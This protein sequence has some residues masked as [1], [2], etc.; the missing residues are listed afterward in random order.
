[1]IKTVRD[2]RWN[3]VGLKALIRENDISCSVDPRQCRCLLHVAC[4]TANIDKVKDLKVI[5]LKVS[6]AN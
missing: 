3:F 5:L 1:L 2:T 4:T 6:L